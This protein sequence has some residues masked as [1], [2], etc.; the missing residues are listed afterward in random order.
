MTKVQLVGSCLQQWAEEA[1]M[2]LY[3]R[4]IWVKDPCWENSKWH[5]SSYRAVDEF[6]YIYIFWKPGITKVKRSRLSSEEWS[7]WVLAACGIFLRLDAIT[8]TKLN[9]PKLSPTE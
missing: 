2:Y 3:D 8:G 5:S 7:A 6:E 4:R 1:G 9:F